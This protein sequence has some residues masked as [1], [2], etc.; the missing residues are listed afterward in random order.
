MNFGLI[1]VKTYYPH[2]INN[3]IGSGKVHIFEYAGS[4]L[5]ILSTLPSIKVAAPVDE[6]RF[7]RRQITY[8]VRQALERTYGW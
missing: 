8:V 4:E 7:T 1:I 6:Y 2:I 5:R 3:G